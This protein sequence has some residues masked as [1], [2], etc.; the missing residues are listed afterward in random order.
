MINILIGTKQVQAATLPTSFP[1]PSHID[2]QH[3]WYYEV[4]MWGRYGENEH[5]FKVDPLPTCYGELS[6]R[7]RPICKTCLTRQ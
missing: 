5:M 3:L 4:R 2:P 6:R 1:H 7:T